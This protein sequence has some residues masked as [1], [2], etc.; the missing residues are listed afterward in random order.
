M[1]KSILLTLSVSFALL[2]T[3]CNKKT[4]SS[5]SEEITAE[6][7]VTVNIPSM[8]TGAKSG[9]YD[10]T[11][12]WSDELFLKDAKKYDKDL[13]LLSYGA[14]MST[15]S[16]S[17]ATK[18]FQD[19]SYDH[20]EVSASY[21]SEPTKDSVRYVMAHKVISDYDLVALS[22]NGL[23]Y[24][25]E[26]ANN[27][28][29]GE[30][31]N[32]EGFA[33]RVSEIE[34]ALQG[35]IKQ[36]TSKRLKLWFNGY[37]RGAGIS[38]LLTNDILRNDLIS[39]AQEN[40]FVYTFEA[41]RGVE[42]TIASPWEN[43]HN[44]MNSADIVTYIA[45]EAYGL[46]RCGNDIDIY[47][48]NV[49]S[50]MKSFDSNIDLAEFVPNEG[51]WEKD[52]DVIDFCIKSLLTKADENNS[53]DTREMFVKNYQEDLGYAIGIVFRLSAPAMDEIKATVSQM[54]FSEL[55]GL[56]DGE[57]LCEFL[58]P[59]LDKYNV[60]CDATKLRAACDTLVKLVTGPGTFLL[61]MLIGNN[62][63]LGRVLAMHYTDTVWV[64]LNNYNSKI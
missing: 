58:K 4:S 27:L 33:A 53:L 19:M 2:L 49:S 64:L 26:W 41:P 13:S 3:G 63:P 35:Y 1:K 16:G 39:V 37:S 30:E 44:I 25:A 8:N 14:S 24:G 51:Y 21:Q 18:F 36:N 50:L 29:I 15:I 34:T 40:M 32:H 42:T 57:A 47:D 62:N 9:G 56:L 10:V 45:P 52:Q 38:N 5:S 61:L 48:P 23:N 17:V 28:T 22:V 59:F 12:N 20:I 6:G 11:L 55:F 54:S 46:S 43:V 60:S 7:K 31:G